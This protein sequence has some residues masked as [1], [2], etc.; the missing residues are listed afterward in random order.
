MRRAAE[1]WRCCIAQGTIGLIGLMSVVQATSDS[2]RCR[3]SRNPSVRGSQ[4]CP[5][6]AKMTWEARPEN[7]ARLSQRASR[8]FRYACTRSVS[9]WYQARPPPPRISPIGRTYDVALSRFAP[10]GRVA[11]FSH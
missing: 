11:S 9:R 6:A 1:V 2:A 7:S 5:A 3:S 10:F 8:S 4:R